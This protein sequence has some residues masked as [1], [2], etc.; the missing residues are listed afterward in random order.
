MKYKNHQILKMKTFQADKDCAPQCSAKLSTIKKK[1][2][3]NQQI[4]TVH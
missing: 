4:K 3:L 1:F 2:V